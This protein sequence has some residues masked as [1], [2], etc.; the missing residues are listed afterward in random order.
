MQNIKKTIKKITKLVGYTSLA[1]LTA[2]SSHKRAAQLNPE[3]LGA[4][5]D[6]FGCKVRLDMQSNQLT[7]INFT[8]NDGFHL[9][10]VTLKWY[11]DSVFTRFQATESD[12]NFAGGFSDGTMTID[13][14][15]CAQPLHKVDIK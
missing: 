10:N 8:N 12:I 15:L 1:A 6:G 9:N 13:G 5:T 2:C 7:L 11:K 3:I 14:T 4:W